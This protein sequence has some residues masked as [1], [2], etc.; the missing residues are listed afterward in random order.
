MAF[1]KLLP[2]RNLYALF[3]YRIQATNIK[4]L[5]NQQ[6]MIY[7]GKVAIAQYVAGRAR[8]PEK[9]LWIGVEAMTYSLAAVCPR[10][11]RLGV[12]VASYS[13]AIGRHCECVRPRMGISLTLGAPNPAITASA[14]PCSSKD[15]SQVMFS[16]TSAE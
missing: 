9:C 11:G 13:L 12:G 14:L 6:N 10:T 5:R 3:S 16:K 4:R 1:K 15:S 2:I 7:F 8:R